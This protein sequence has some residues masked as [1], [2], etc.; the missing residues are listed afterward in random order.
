MNAKKVILILALIVVIILFFLA[1]LPSRI[2]TSL[3]GGDTLPKGTA[4]VSGKSKPAVVAKKIPAPPVEIILGNQTGQQKIVTRKVPPQPS[5]RPEIAT[6]PPED[7]KLAATENKVPE[8]AKTTEKVPEKTPPPKPQTTTPKVEQAPAAKP[9]VATKPEPTKTAQKKAAVTDSTPSKPEPVPGRET[10]P[11]KPETTAP[12]KTAV[13]KTE[14]QKSKPDP[15]L[16]KPVKTPQKTTPAAPPKDAVATKSEPPKT[17]Q[18]PAISMAKK[19][20]YSIMLAS[21]RLKK[22]AQ[23]VVSVN[24]KKGLKPHIVKVDLGPKGEWW[25]VF[26]GQYRNRGEALKVRKDLKLK[27]ALIKKT[28]YANEIGIFDSEIQTMGMA[29]RLEKLGYS[30]YV[31]KAQDNKWRLVTG[32]FVSH[33]GAKL[34]KSEL[35]AKGVQ[36]KIVER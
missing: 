35:A 23:E 13:A 32:A 5:P 27:D 24:R 2:I 9:P 17:S 33:D 21:C 34:Q 11:K 36:S 7:Q 25:R 20:P 15:A 29:K 10:A 6:P 14:P 31:I 3:T 16:K 18:K 1:G 28:P 30:P 19:Y 22:S 4:Q 12:A 26:A 8:P